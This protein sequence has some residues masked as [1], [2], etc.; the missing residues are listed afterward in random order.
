MLHETI[1]GET[2]ELIK[3]YLVDNSV[4]ANEVKCID[5]WYLSWVEYIE[6]S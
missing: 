4:P 2:D 5:M 6:C 1:D 3:W